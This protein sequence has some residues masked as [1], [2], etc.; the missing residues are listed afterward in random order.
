MDTEEYFEYDEEYYN[1]DYDEN[2]KSFYSEDFNDD[3][4]MKILNIY[5]DIK[6]YIKF[7]SIPLCEMLKP[8]DIYHI[9]ER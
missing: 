1:S 6:G 3:Y 5:Q 9:L 8:E 4:D 7:E 2:E